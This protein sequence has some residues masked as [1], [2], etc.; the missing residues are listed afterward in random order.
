MPCLVRD[1][2]FHDEYFIQTLNEREIEEGKY[3]GV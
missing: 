1:Y 3:E 2:H